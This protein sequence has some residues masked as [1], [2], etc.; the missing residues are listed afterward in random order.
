MQVAEFGAVGSGAIAEAG[1]LGFA[2]LLPGLR[3]LTGTVAAAGRSASGSIAGRAVT[4]LVL[5]GH[6]VGGVEHL[7]QGG[8]PGLGRTTTARD[9]RPITRPVRTI[10]RISAVRRPPI[11][12]VRTIGAPV[13]LRHPD[14]LRSPY[15]LTHQ[16]AI[17]VPGRPGRN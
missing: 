5:G 12:R 9:P 8:P 7:P 2:R 1:E 16:V 14:R 11:R 3:T 6:L 17:L 4:G 15:C 10:T 13:Q